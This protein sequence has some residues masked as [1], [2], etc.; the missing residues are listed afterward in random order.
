MLEKS[1][2]F[3][4]FLFLQFCDVAPVAIVG[5]YIQSNMETFKI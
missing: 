3:N 2:F 1:F 4:F 5:K